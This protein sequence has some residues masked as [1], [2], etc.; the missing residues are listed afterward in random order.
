MRRTHISSDT[1]TKISMRLAKERLMTVE[2]MH[3]KAGRSRRRTAKH[4]RVSAD[5]RA[6]MGSTSVKQRLQRMGAVI[7]VYWDVPQVRAHGQR[8]ATEGARVLQQGA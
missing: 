1:A 7:C 4:R 8:K 5:A 6:Q 3:R 2:R